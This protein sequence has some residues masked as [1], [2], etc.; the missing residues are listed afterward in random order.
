MELELNKC[1]TLLRKELNAMNK[2]W[3]L[4]SEKLY[5]KNCHKLQL[6]SP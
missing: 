3:N 4:M 1:D 5:L 2:K 6:I